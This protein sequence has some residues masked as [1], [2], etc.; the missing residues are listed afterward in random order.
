MGQFKKFLKSSGYKPL[1]S[2]KWEDVY[3]HS[4][5]DEHPMCYVNWYDA[6]AYAE[7][8]GRRLPTEAEWR[9]VARGGLDGKKFP[10]GDDIDVARDYANYAGTDRKDNWDK[11][12]PVGSFEPN[13]YGLFDMVGNVHEW[14]QD[15][16]GSDKK[17][18]VLCGGH[19]FDTLYSLRV[20]Y[21]YGSNPTIEDLARGFRCVVDVPKASLLV[22]D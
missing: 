18:K 16:Y 14:S 1:K 17:N 20:G 13:G 6:V 22:G 4:P 11:A 12:S 19:W 2:I 15:W 7:W 21:R 3:E 8:V 9:F 10:W 5:T